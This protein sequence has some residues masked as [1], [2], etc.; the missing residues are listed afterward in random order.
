MSAI[1]IGHALPPLPDETLSQLEIV[2]AE[3]AHQARVAAE[4]EAAAAAAAAGGA[5]AAAYPAPA[6]R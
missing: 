6:P 4:A 3:L 5:G 1:S 2:H